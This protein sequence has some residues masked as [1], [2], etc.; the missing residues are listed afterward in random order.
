MVS[1]CRGSKR[2]STFENILKRPLKFPSDPVVSP[3]C[4]VGSLLLPVRNMPGS[5]AV[6]LGYVL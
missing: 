3:E 2:D 6:C 4:Q 1:C 5:D